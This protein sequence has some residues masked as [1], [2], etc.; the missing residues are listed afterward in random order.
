MKTPT[1]SRPQC[2]GLKTEPN[3]VGI[4]VHTFSLSN[5]SR[6]GTGR[7]TSWQRQRKDAETS[8]NTFFLFRSESFTTSVDCTHREHTTAHR[9]TQ[10][11]QA[12]P[13]FL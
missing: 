3:H 4:C 10:Q 1:C 5:G 9:R 6:P 12:S 13:R 2:T 11:I 7:L 8:R